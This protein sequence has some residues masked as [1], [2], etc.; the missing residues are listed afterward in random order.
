MTG[1]DSE[2]PREIRVHRFTE[3]QNGSIRLFDAIPD[4]KPLRTFSGIA[5]AEGLGVDPG[6]SGKFSFQHR[7]SKPIGVAGDIQ[8][9]NQKASK[10]KDTNPSYGRNISQILLASSRS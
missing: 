1:R 6:P 9:E 7:V 4:G 8:D 10:E 5:L 3:T 2:R